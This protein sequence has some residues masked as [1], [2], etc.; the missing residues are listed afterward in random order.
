[1]VEGRGNHHRFIQER[2][3]VVKALK[4]GVRAI[5]GYTTWTGYGTQGWGRIESLYSEHDIFSGS[6]PEEDGKVH[7]WI[8]FN[9]ALSK[10]QEISCGHRRIM[11]DDLQGMLPFFR[12]GSFIVPVQKLDVRARFN[13]DEDPVSVRAASWKGVK[14]IPCNLE[15]VRLVNTQERTVEYAVEVSNPPKGVSFGIRWKWS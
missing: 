2:R 5:E 13:R 3:V 11:E 4:D 8:Y 15:V 10:G 6:R 1:M 9:G 14:E 12:Q 7:Y